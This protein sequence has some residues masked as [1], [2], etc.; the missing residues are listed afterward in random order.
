M[1]A[2]TTKCESEMD[3]LGV[4]SVSG[5]DRA[6]SPVSEERGLRQDRLCT[7]DLCCSELQN[8]MGKW[9]YWSFGRHVCRQGSRRI[10]P[11]SYRRPLMIF[12]LLVIL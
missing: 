2:A 12:R 8:G 1:N 3:D 9:D 5:E 4:E 7:A 10:L 6:S 11:M